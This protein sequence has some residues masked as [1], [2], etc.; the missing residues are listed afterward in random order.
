MANRFR[1]PPALATRLVAGARPLALAIGLV[2][3]VSLW[4]GAPAEALRMLRPQAVQVMPAP[5]SAAAPVPAPVVRGV[6]TPDIIRRVIYVRINEI[7]SCYQIELQMRPGLAGRLAVR[8]EIDDAGKVSG[9]HVRENSIPID[10][11]QHCVAEA[12]RQWEYPATYNGGVT[13][14]TY[15]FVLR[16]KPLEENYV[17]IKISDAELER[18]GIYKEDGLPAA[19]ILF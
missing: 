7:R 4:S 2:A 8:F 12:M 19:D 16:P 11:L 5:S 13:V 15:P 1:R 14:V 17:G 18:L 10:S 3:G 9:L 6:L